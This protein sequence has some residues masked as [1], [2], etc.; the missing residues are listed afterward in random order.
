M[1]QIASWAGCWSFAVI[2]GCM[3]CGW[4]TMAAA[5]ASSAGELLADATPVADLS[6]A[7]DKQYESRIGALKTRF[8]M[9]FGSRHDNFNWSIAGDASGSNPNIISELDWSKVEAYQMRLGNRTQVGKW[10]YFRGQFQY[11]WIQD[12]SVRDSDYRSDNRGDEYSR[13]ISDSSGDQLWDLSFG[14]GY[15]FILAKGSLRIAP[16]LGFSISKQN[17][18]ITNG[19][20]VIGTGPPETPDLGPLDSRLNS[21]YRAKWI[22]PWIGCDL[23]YQIEPKRPGQIPMELGASLELHWAAYSGQGNWNLRGDLQHPVSFEH[24]ADGFGIRI[25]VEWLIRFAPNW[26]L[27][28]AADYLNWST[29]HGVNTQYG[30]SGTN[31]SRLNEVEWEARSFMVGVTYYFFGK[32]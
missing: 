27:S 9:S 23:R 19:Y 32:R 25:E 31:V 14:A 11:A 21:T 2:L 30:T 4:V 12:G 15:P 29:D 17:F 18:R 3:I 26:D 13:S 1:R 10:L 24:Q 22:G 28:L 7:P 20:Q 5:G 6:H 8:D 16:L